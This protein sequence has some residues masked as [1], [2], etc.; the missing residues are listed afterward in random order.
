MSN[1]V[2]GMMTR[3][4]V[5]RRRPLL[6]RLTHTARRA[7]IREPRRE[8]RAPRARRAKGSKRV[9]FCLVTGSA[10]VVG[11]TTTRRTW[12]AS[13]VRLAHARLRVKGCKVD[14]GGLFPLGARVSLFVRV[15]RA[16]LLVQGPLP[17]G[18][19][20]GFA[21]FLCLPGASL[22]SA[23]W[24]SLCPALARLPGVS[25]AVRDQRR[26]RWV[27]WLSLWGGLGASLWW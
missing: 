21:F 22:L 7:R 18:C 27:L 9:V 23:C 17:L 13:G 26:R 8:P 19:P 3:W 14:S 16:R 24:S 6:H 1:A 25:W 10:P 20:A 4:E 12:F 5:P 15:G 11:L 2:A